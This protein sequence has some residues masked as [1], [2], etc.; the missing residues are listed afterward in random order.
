[1]ALAFDEPNVAK[2]LRQIPGPLLTEWL[3]YYELEPWGEERADYREYLAYKA[4]NQKSYSLADFIY[5]PD[6]FRKPK[7]KTVDQIKDVLMTL[8]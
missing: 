3:E 8:L 4:S 1:L 6:A 5:D 7:G 2:L